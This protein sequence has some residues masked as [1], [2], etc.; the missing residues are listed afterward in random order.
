MKRRRWLRRAG[1]ILLG[2]TV[3]FVASTVL[4]VA[5]LRF[6]NPP[7]TAFIVERGGA[8]RRTWV[9]LSAIS[10]E[11]RLAV[12]ASEDQKFP[13][14][15]G[16]DVTAIADAVEERL[17]GHA[18][19]GA[20]T[21][22]QQVAK[23]LFLWSGKS[24]LRKGLEAYFT[25]LIE[26]CWSKRR[27][28]EVHLNVAEW[29]NGLYGAEAAS[30]AYFGKSARELTAEESAALAACLP[31]PRTRS[32]VAMSP[33]VETRATWVMDQAPRL[34]VVGGAPMAELLAP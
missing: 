9:P 18:L 11:L 7:T 10:P 26:L 17:E 28:L 24:L 6:V 32:P 15:H 33:V 19:R 25:V 1:K 29:G 13:V 3:A 16:F 27:I 12:I 14:H 20:S 4:V 2:A 22:S 5:A 21:L 8:V 23:N 30:R 31:S 34:K